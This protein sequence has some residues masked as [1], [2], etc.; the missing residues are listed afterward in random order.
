VLLRFNPV[1]CKADFM[2]GGLDFDE[3]GLGELMLVKEVNLGR[4]GFI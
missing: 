4:I 1:D 2:S 3:V